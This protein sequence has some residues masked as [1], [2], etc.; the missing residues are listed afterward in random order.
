MWR[1]VPETAYPVFRRKMF[2]K[3][4]GSEKRTVRKKDAWKKDSQ[5]KDFQRR[6]GRSSA[7]SSKHISRPSFG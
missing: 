3:E 7:G 6:E 5:K 1:G 4:N 2:G